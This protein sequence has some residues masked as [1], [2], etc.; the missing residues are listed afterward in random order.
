MICM[1]LPHPKDLFFAANPFGSSPCEAKP[2]DGGDGAVQDQ[3]QEQEQEQGGG[4]FLSYLCA[5]IGANPQVQTAEDTLPTNR[6][7]CGFVREVQVST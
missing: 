5:M 2:F 6:R 3:E 1:S 4:Y 7:R